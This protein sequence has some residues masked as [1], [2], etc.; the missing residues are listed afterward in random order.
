[1]RSISAAVWWLATRAFVLWL[2]LGPENWVTG[3]IAYFERSLS[4]LSAQ[5]I[6]TSLVEYP[7]LG[8][9]LVAFP[10]LVS[11]WVGH[12]DLYSVIVM[13]LAMVTDAA[14]TVLMFRFGRSRRTAALWVWLLAVP[15]LG[16][17]TYAR[18]DLVPGVLVGVA[19][20]LL[21]T[22]PRIA[23]VAGAMATGLKFWPALLLPALAARRR[24]RVRVVVVVGAIG[25]LLAGVSLAVAGW[26]RLVSPLVWQ[27]DRGL[28]IES[29]PATPAMLAWALNGSDHVVSYTDYNAFEVEGRGVAALIAGSDLMTLLLVLALVA[30]WVKA[31]RRGDVLTGDAVVWMCLAAVTAFMVSS[32][33]LSP[34][35]LLWLLPAAAAGLAVAETPRGVRQLRWFAA[36]LLIA[37]GVT[38]LIF[39]VFYAGLVSHNPQSLWVV[40]LLVARNAMLV[41][42]L[43]QAVAETWWHLQHSSQRGLHRGSELDRQ[44]TGPDGNETRSF[45]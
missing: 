16:A 25:S 28:Q 43:F 34:Q 21:T 39:P 15:L 3:D 22:H 33:V 14:F 42:L 44:P 6:A 27:S 4:D 5:G 26:G 1:M 11:Q 24:D 45:R 29:V 23:A 12:P 35:Y 18:F 30:M 10:W 19:V 9:A 38:H 40:L 17:T 41:W 36:V 8:V 31:W 37:T 7:L 2:F 32:K 13:G 20:L